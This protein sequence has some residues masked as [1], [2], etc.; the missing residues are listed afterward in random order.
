MTRRR[1]I[2]STHHRQA[3][4]VIDQ[5]EPGFFLVQEAPGAA[6]MPARIVRPCPIEF[7]VDAP[8][9]WLD[10]WP[11]LRADIDGRP[12]DVERVWTSRRRISMA[13]WLYLTRT[14]EWERRHAPTS[15]M[16]NPRQPIDLL[17]SPIPF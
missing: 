4:R 1:H 8:W 10:R 3:T 16:A 9:Q 13:E 12:A 7:S 17:I 6:W 2:P 14:A 15:P 11:P 5:P